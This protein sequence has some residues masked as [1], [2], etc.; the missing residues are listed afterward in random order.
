LVKG[1]I[2]YLVLE[3][4]S[5]GDCVGLGVWYSSYGREDRFIQKFC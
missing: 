4:A 5:E 1:T 2:L 3:R